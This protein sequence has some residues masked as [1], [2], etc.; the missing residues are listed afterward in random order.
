[1]DGEA[2]G[3]VAS[4]VKE[5][6]AD[7]GF[8]AAIPPTVLLPTQNAQKLPERHTTGNETIQLYP[9][10]VAAPARIVLTLLPSR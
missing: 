1:L 5:I 4:Q 3:K 6:D 7:F 9:N 8:P 10:S 2:S